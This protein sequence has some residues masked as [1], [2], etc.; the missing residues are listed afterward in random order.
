MQ[1]FAG[2]AR[3]FSHIALSLLVAEP[4][5]GGNG[6]SPELIERL[7]LKHPGGFIG[8]RSFFLAMLISGVKVG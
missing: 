2:I 8:L 4:V 5:I 6:A 7:A 1:R 3:F